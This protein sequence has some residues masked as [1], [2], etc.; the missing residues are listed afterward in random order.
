MNSRTRTMTLKYLW[1]LAVLIV[2]G[3]TAGSAS[4]Q[5][6]TVD[7]TPLNFGVVTFSSAVRS[8][9]STATVSATCTGQP[10]EVVRICPTLAAAAGSSN[11]ITLLTHTIDSSARMSYGLY[12][13]VARQQPLA[14]GLDVPL[15]QSGRG[16]ARYT[17]YGR[18][19][20]NAASNR[21]G[22]YSVFV[23]LGFSGDYVSAG[24]ASCRGQLDPLPQALAK[25]PPGA[26]TTLVR[27]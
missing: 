14:I 20:A 5:V 17:I 6:C 7:L 2:A 26:K 22:T 11:K 18:L 15:D 9:D 23:D 8:N 1:F 21:A 16:T 4:A 27:K 25:R 24:P 10:G 3:T 19:F 12:S 13:D